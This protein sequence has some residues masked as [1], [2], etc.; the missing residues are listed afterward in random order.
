[1]RVTRP[2][3][4]AHAA[5]E[6]VLV[7]CQQASDLEHGGVG[8]AVVHGAVVPGVDVAVEH[9]VGVFSGAGQVAR[10]CRDLAPGTIGLGHEPYG[11]RPLLHGRADLLPVRLGHGNGW[12]LGEQTGGLWY[13]GSPDR[14]D[15]HLVDVFVVDVDLG[16][17]SILL[18]GQRLVGHRQ[19]VADDDLAPH[20]EPLV[21]GR[22]A[23]AHEDEFASYAVVVGERAQGVAVA[24]D[25]H[26]L[27][28]NH[29]Q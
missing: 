13:W 10:E 20:V 9:D 11:D 7:L 16:D 28:R 27:W 5:I 8:G 14:R 29:L 1:M 6:L 12:K 21:I 22:M 2:E 4:H 26:L 3:G 23:V 15:A 25:R 19:T 24:G 17:G 18:R